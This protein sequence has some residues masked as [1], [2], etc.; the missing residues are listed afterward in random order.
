VEKIELHEYAKGVVPAEV[1]SS[2]PSAALEAQALAALTFARFAILHPRHVS[3]GADLCDSTCCQAYDPAKRSAQTDKAVEAVRDCYI[4]HVPAGA[5]PIEA[6]YFAHCNGKTRNSEDYD[7]WR[8]VPYLRS[9]PCE[10]GYY[11]YYGHGVGMCQ[12][13]AK[14][15]ADQ[16]ATSAEIAEHYYTNCKV[17]GAPEPPPRPAPWWCPYAMA[18]ADWLDKLIACKCRS[19]GS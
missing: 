3:Q 6:L 15:M 7:D 13:G 11:D 5:N 17:G 10:C 16:G 19:E 8:Q 2:W 12:W 4:Y 1:Y 14:I 9:V 18:F